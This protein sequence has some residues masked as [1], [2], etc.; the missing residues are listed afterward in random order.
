MLNR[1]FLCIMALVPFVSSVNGEIA[2]VLRSGWG[3]NGAPPPPTIK[4]LALHDQNGAV[5]EVRG[6]YKIIDPNTNKD[7]T[8][9]RFKG[10]SQY[11]QAIPSGLKWGEEFPG[12]HQLQ[13]IPTGPETE[14]LLNNNYFPGSL[15]VYNIGGTIS[16]VNEL[17]IEDYLINTLPNKFPQNLSD[18]TLAALVI[19]E[20]TNAY[21]QAQHPKNNFFSADG[22]QVGYQG[23]LKIDPNSPLQKAIR[24]TRYMVMSRT[25]LYEGV[26]TPF[27]IQWDNIPAK[28]G[29][30]AKIESSKITVAQADEMAKKGDHAAIILDKA[31]PHSTIQLI[32]FSER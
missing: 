29:S 20:R 22:T 6:K 14:I 4:V 21:F 19:S 18:E 28:L 1:F 8:G 5:L 7:I 31:F 11:I 9:L 3:Q 12:V 24:N 25:G 32:R 17:P 30:D 26:I 16:V 10:K 27:A 2:S 23:L 15:L 13:I